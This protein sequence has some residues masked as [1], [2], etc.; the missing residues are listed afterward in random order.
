MSANVFDVFYPQLAVGKRHQPLLTLADGQQ[1]SRQ[2]VLEASGRLANFFVAQGLVPG[3]RVTVQIDKGPLGLCLYLACLRAGLVY[4]PLNTGYQPAELA[5][6]LEN[7]EPSAVICS[8]AYEAPLTALCDRLG[9]ERRWTLNGDDTG[10]L[11]D[12]SGAMAVQFETVARGP[13]D[14]AALLYSSGTTGRPK[15]IMLSHANMA[16]SA[17]ALHEAWAFSESDRLL[18]MLPVFHVHGLFVA[19]HCVLM[20][21]AQ[22]VYLPKFDAQ[23]ALR[24]LPECTVMMGVPTFYT[25]L[26]DARIGREHCPNVRVFI[27]GSAPLLAETFRDF[28]AATGHRILER[29]GMTETNMNTSNPL[30][31]E[32]RAGTVGQAL[33]GVGLQVV[34]DAGQP[35]PPGEVGSI[36]VK[37]ANVFQGYWRMPEKTAEDIGADG[38]F[39]TGDKGALSADGYLSII[40]RAKDLIITGGLNVYPKEV[41]LLIDEQPGVLESAV[42][43]VPHPDFGEAVV[44]VVVGDAQWPDVQAA[45]A[46]GLAKFKQPKQY[47]AVKELPRNTMGKVQKA[48]LRAQYQ[49]LFQS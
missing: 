25:R 7:A 40:G 36:Q 44:A 27:S 34:D 4:H 33:P 31:G 5:Y 32:R 45:V 28:E 10:T 26:L 30:H 22:M 39:N 13:D 3:D 6:F 21:G 2:Q 29:Y 19:I 43:G 18:H 48:A 8:S 37:G 49:G 1:W 23:Q 15:G 20:S 35:L 17:R 46:Q 14:L 42:I 41:E 16:A 12:A 24:W 47:I 9:I 11:V 38:F